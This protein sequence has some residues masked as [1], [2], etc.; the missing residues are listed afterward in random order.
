MNNKIDKN[1]KIFIAGATGMV[2][3]AIRRELINSG[4]G[5][6]K[7]KILAPPRS[8]LNLLNIYEIEKWFEVNK[9][10]IVI[11]AAAKVGGILANNTNPKDFILENLKIQTNLIETSYRKGVKRLLFLGSSCIYP[12]FAKQPIR[13]ESLLDGKLES[14]NEYYAL[15]KITGIKLCESLRKQDNFDAICL[16]PTNLYG[17]GDNY[18]LKNSHVLPALIRKFYEAKINKSSIVT[19]WGSGKPE[20][21]FLHVDDLAKA[22]RF[23]LENWD[24]NETS[25]PKDK[26]GNPLIFLNIGSGKDLS[27]KELAKKIAIEIGFKGE[28]KWDISKPDGTPKKLLDISRIKSLGWQPT[29]SLD[30]GITKTVKLFEKIYWKNSNIEKN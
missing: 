20:R 5:M 29:I 2:G 13:E 12:K 15:A 18:H 3:S 26:D 27:I 11:I 6:L 1:D 9:P 19:C 21:E 4:Y 16:M 7:N 25:A 14:T 24:P 17:P 8:E 22:C 30:E 23:V 28:I 10:N